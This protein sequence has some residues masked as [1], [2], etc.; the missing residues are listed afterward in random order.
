MNPFKPSAKVIGPIGGKSMVDLIRD[1]RAGRLKPADVP[2][3]VR[4]VVVM[5]A[6]TLPDAAIAEP[7]GQPVDHHRV[8]GL[9]PIRH[10]RS[11]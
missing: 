3:G 6:K 2:D 7:K 10:T 4:R 9:G 5:F 8:E 1:V 11:A